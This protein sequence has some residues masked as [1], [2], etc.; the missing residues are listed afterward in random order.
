MWPGLRPETV[1]CGHRLQGRGYLH[2]CPPCPWQGTDRPMFRAHRTGPHDL[3]ERF[4]LVAGGQ[5]KPYPPPHCRFPECVDK[6]DAQQ[7]HRTNVRCFCIYRKNSLKFSINCTKVKIET[8][9]LKNHGFRD[10]AG[11]KVTRTLPL[12]LSQAACGPPNLFGGLQA[13]FFISAMEVKHMTRRSNPPRPRGPPEAPQN[14]ESGKGVHQ[15]WITTLQTIPF[16]EG[17]C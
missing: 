3:P 16:G 6:K 4:G 8:P 13:A 1:P 7:K 12:S 2:D 15:P 17:P 9:F 11:Q 10:A 5:G 14:T